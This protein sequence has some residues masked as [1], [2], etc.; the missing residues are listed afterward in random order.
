MH[1][2]R[3]NLRTAHNQLAEP[4]IPRYDR[5]TIFLGRALKSAS[6]GEGLPLQFLPKRVSSRSLS[7][8]SDGAG[9]SGEA[10]Y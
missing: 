6:L 2:V 1:H 10:C 3:I 7:L 4:V 9:A 5:N 8:Q